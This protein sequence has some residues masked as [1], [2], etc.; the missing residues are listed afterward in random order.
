MTTE[1]FAHDLSEFVAQAEDAGLSR[2]QVI[3][4]LQEQVMAMQESEAE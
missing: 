1:Q 2:P 4:L 3:A